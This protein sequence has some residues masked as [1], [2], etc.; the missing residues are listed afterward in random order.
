MTLNQLISLTFL[1]YKRCRLGLID[2]ENDWEPIN[3]SVNRVINR[4]DQSINQSIHRAINQS[5]MLH[6]V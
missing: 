1:R 4:L 6:T 3:H 5:I 2:V